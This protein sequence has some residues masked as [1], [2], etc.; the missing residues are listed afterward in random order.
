MDTQEYI[1][2]Q[3]SIKS[4]R[5]IKSGEISSYELGM[6]QG[7]KTERRNLVQTLNKNGFTIEDIASATGLSNSEIMSYLAE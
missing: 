5:D 4:Y 7:R 6:E 3:R 2:Y 1:A